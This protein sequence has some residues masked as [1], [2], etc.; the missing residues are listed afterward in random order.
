MRG[1]ARAAG[2]ILN[3]QGDMR[4]FVRLEELPT[5]KPT[6]ALPGRMDGLG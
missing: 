6:A 5:A 4:L 3:R 1:E 2:Q